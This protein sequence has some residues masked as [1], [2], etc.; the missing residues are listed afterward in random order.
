MNPL[1]QWRQ[2]L[3][4]KLRNEGRVETSVVVK[5]HPYIAYHPTNKPLRGWHAM[6]EKAA[7]SAGEL[8]RAIKRA[9]EHEHLVAWVPYWMY[10]ALFP[11]EEEAAAMSADLWFRRSPD[12]LYA[13][14]FSEQ[15]LA[16]LDTVA[17]IS[18]AVGVW[19]LILEKR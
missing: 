9:Y 6:P 12:T 2:S 10:V 13:A 3:R 15:G 18:G 19:R 7:M 11:S 14:R 1:E 5:G 8:R 4:I 17:R 16:A